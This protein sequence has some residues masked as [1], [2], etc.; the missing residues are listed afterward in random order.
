[1]KGWKKDSCPR[2]KKP[3]GKSQEVPVG[4][5]PEKVPVQETL[6]VL[7][8]RL[9][10]LVVPVDRDQVVSRLIAHAEVAGPHFRAALAWFL[11]LHK[12]PKEFT[13]HFPRAKM[14]VV[15]G[16]NY[17]LPSLVKF[18]PQLESTFVQEKTYSKS[19][20]AVCPGDEIEMLPKSKAF[21]LE[22]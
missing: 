20:A 21:Q 16:H 3:L 15:G 11:D 10:P 4:P 12:T 8:Q 5:Q 19:E 18:L 22:D 2:C 9:I 7:A 13:K 6:E 1:V 14:G 17:Y